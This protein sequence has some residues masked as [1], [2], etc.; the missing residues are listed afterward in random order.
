MTIFLTGVGAR[1]LAR[2]IETRHPEGALQ[3]ALR[4]LIVV[5][6]GR[7]TVR[8]VMR[9]NGKS[10]SRAAAAPEPN[11]WRELLAALK[12]RPETRITVQEYGKS[13]SELL[14]GLRARRCPGGPEVTAVPVYQWA[15][16]DD[17][18]PDGRRFLVVRPPTASPIMLLLDWRLMD[19]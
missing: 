3:E 18:G 8:A 2:V 19:T 14:E 9:A 5:V 1:Y 4:G 10:P 15:M 12:G 17:T 7:E 11:T 16:P 13:T 6:R